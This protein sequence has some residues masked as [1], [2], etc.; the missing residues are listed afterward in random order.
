MGMTVGYFEPTDATHGG[1]IAP[2]MPQ[3]FE[4][5]SKQRKGQRR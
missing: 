3:V 5:L 2:T 1:M 4:F